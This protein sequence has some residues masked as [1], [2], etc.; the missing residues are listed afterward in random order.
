MTLL[1][2]A[3][4]QQTPSRSGAP[5][6]SREA[7]GLPSSPSATPRVETQVQSPPLKG[8]TPRALASLHLT[9][10]AKALL[11]SGQADDAISVLERSVNLNPSNGQ[12]YYYLAEA[13]LKKGNPNQA[14]EFNRL[15][16]MYL[17]ADPEWT[18]RVKA[19]AERIKMRL[20][21]MSNCRRTAFP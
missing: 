19:Q 20:Q 3:I 15:A 21:S 16:A 1:S 12:N 4:S 10:E 17:R 11:D 13:W 2:C 14:R 6:A 18:D 5:A 7:Q 8:D 9:E